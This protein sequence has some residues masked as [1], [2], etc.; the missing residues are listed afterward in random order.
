MADTSMARKLLKER[1]DASTRDSFLGAAH[2]LADDVFDAIDGCD[3]DPMEALALVYRSTTGV[4]AFLRPP[5]RYL[6]RKARVI[7]M[8]R[9]LI[10][11]DEPKALYAYDREARRSEA[12]AD[13]L[14]EYAAWLASGGKSDAT[15]ATR[16]QRSNVLLQHLEDSGVTD[17]AEL[18][19]KTLSSFVAWLDGRYTAV[20]RSNILY[21]LRNLFTCPSVQDRMTFDPFGLLEG[22]HTPKH[23]NVPSTYSQDEVRAILSSIDRETHA[24][25]TLYLVVVLA[26]VYG[27]RSGDIRRLRL[28]DIDFRA[29]GIG[30]VQ[31]KTGVPISLPLVDE[32]RLPLLDYLMRTRRECSHREVL[33]RHRGAA[34]PYLPSNHFS[35]PL[36]RAIA[37]SGVDFGERKTGLHALRHSLATSMLASGVPV[38]EIAGVLGHTSA[39]ST[40]AYIWSDVERLRMAA[41]E[42]G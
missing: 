6:M 34:V 41:I 18:D 36:R 29:C 24:G 40:K 38:S 1:I 16:V 9:D 37:A 11:G 12:F 14:R 28:D 32:V 17:L 20:G 15:V 3:D 31:H 2:R 7:M 4:E 25:R 42:V 39:E 5:T 19:A 27:L 8:A 23:S 21:T 10:A 35:S 26:A 30:I 13:V 33:I 22:I